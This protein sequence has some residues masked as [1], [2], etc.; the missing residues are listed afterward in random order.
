VTVPASHKAPGVSGADIVIY[1]TMR[2]TESGVLA[3]AIECLSSAS[4]NRPIAGQV[5]IGPNSFGNN[6]LSHIAGIVLHEV[7]HI[8]GFS[9]NKYNEFIKSDGSP[10][11][12]VTSSTTRSYNGQSKTI[13][14]IVTPQ[15]V[16]VAKQHY[17]CSTADGV[18]LEEYGGSGTAGSHF[19]KRQVMNDYMVGSASW[20]NPSETYSISSFSLALLEDSGWYRANYSAADPLIYGRNTGC[21]ILNN[22]CSAWNLNNFE[23]YFCNDGNPQ[24]A[25]C[26]FDLKAK[27]YCGL[28]KYQSPGLPAYY[29]YFSDPTVGGNDPY[30]D[31]CPVIL[32]YSNGRCDGA[33]SASAKIGEV[34]GQSSA[35]FDSALGNVLNPPAT[36]DATCL[37]YRCALVNGGPTTTLQVGVDGNWYDC[38]SD[39]QVKRIDISGTVRGY[40]KC[41]NN[42]YQIL[43]ANVPGVVPSPSQP[44]GKDCGNGIF[45]FFCSDANKVGQ[46]SVLMIALIGMIL[47]FLL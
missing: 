43:C 27:G 41:P 4:D 25:Y 47:S 14:K 40:V 29:Q 34:Y 45:S 21:N 22:R 2:P 19:E 24:N 46:V 44:G 8:L 10:Q 23:G 26:S 11:S 30:M 42:G 31:Y 15:I 33:G 37:Q 39:G 32:R 6:Q 13:Q 7:T 12:P 28:A 35:C 3:W 16:A 20:Y 5:N 36:K 1:V 17:Q 9:S 38:G 18:E